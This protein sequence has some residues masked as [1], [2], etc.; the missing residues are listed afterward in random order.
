MERIV[1]V[2]VGILIFNEN[3]EVLL[4]QRLNSHGAHQWETPGGHLEFGESFET[5]AI[6]ETKEETGL[7]IHDPQFCYLSNDFF[8]T[9]NKHYVTILMRAACPPNQAV[10]NLEPHKRGGWQWFDF[11]NLPTNLF[12]PLRHLQKDQ[13][14]GWE[15]GHDPRAELG[16]R[17]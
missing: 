2:G 8:E 12:V 10:S 11:H 13:S 3:N 17:A 1:R 6:R 5:C 14:Y 4:G 9:E 7:I 16:Q 15:K